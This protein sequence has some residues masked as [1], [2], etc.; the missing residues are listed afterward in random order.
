MNSNVTKGV[1]LE[2]ITALRNHVD[3]K[4]ESTYADTNARLDRINDHLESLN[5]SVARHEAL[6]AAIRVELDHLKDSTK[7]GAMHAPSSHD[8]MPALT[9]GDVRRIGTLV[10]GGVAVIEFL[11]RAVPYLSALAKAASK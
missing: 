8:S 11:M 3:A 5:G 4:F 9:K 1:L 10:A 6:H 7:R 2:V